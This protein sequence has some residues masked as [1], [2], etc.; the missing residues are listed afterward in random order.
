MNEI[1]VSVVGNV[2][3]DVTFRKTGNG[4]SLSS[5]RLASSTRYYDKGRREWTDGT[6][7]WFSVFCFRELAEHASSSLSKGDPILVTGRLTARNWEKDGRTGTSLELEARH[8]GHDQSRG[9]SVF[10]RRVRAARSDDTGEVLKEIGEAMATA[11]A[12]PAEGEGLDA[13]QAA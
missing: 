12:E 7:T 9:T 6:T 8:L 3:S 11:P 4:T 5:F 1:I 2:A 13:G 10:K